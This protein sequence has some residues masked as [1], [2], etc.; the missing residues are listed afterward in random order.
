MVKRKEIKCHVFDTEKDWF[1]LNSTPRKYATRYHHEVAGADLFVAY[2]NYASKWFVEY[3]VKDDRADRGMDI[4]DKLIFF[5]NDM[6]TENIQ[7]LFD[8][9][10]NAISYTEETKKRCYFIYTFSGDQKKIEERGKKLLLYLANKRRGDQFTVT[11]HSRLI[12]DPLGEMLVNP[13]G[14]IKS[15]STLL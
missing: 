2:F 6:G 10:E 1:H 8:K 12:S 3:K 7:V 15:L 9:V 11:N 13:K 5:E 14:E 4:F